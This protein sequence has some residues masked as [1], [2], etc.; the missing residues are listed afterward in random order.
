V[1]QSVYRL[2]YGLDDQGSIP[3]R[4]NDRILSLR[5]HIH[6]DSEDHTASYPMGTGGSSP[7]DKAIGA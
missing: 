4:S 1:A 3:S 5:Q 2:G 7:G 6:T